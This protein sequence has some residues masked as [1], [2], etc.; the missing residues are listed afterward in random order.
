MATPSP[1]IE[2]ILVPYDFGEPAARALLQKKKNLR[3]MRKLKAVQGKEDQI[4]PP[5]CGEIYRGAIPDARL[6]T[7][8]GAGHMPEM[9]KPEEFVRAVGDF[10]K[11]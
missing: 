8:A 4:T 9:E 11:T 2:K 10:L 1:R 3:L 6:L 5:D 7:I